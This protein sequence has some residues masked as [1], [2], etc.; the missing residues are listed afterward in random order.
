MMII[1]DAEL[2]K[3][4]GGGNLWQQRQSLYQR[5]IDLRMELTGID[6]RVATRRRR[7]ADLIPRIPELA[8]RNFELQHLAQETERLRRQFDR[9]REKEFEIRTALRRESSQMERHESATRPQCPW[10]APGFAST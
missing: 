3:G 5:Q 2:M 9:L 7:L 6:I 4:A 10:E 1:G 8:N